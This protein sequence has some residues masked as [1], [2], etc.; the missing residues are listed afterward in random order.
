M[1]VTEGYKQIMAEVRVS[2]DGYDQWGSVMSNLFG[3]ATVAYVEFDEIM[4]EFRP[5]PFLA[6]GEELDDYPDKIFQ[7]LVHNGTVTLDDLE[8][9]YQVLSRFEGLIPQDEKY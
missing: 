3:V 6:S 7:D 8:Q 9:V 1:P 2:W 4:P 5:S